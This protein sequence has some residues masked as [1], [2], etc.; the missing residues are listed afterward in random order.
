MWIS[1]RR[2][3]SLYQQVQNLQSDV[4][5]LKFECYVRNDIASPYAD[6]SNTR[7][8][9]PLRDIVFGMAKTLGVK[10]DVDYA[11]DAQAKVTTVRESASE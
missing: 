1:R 6:P 11:K 3:E 9:V 4:A 10:I 5:R 2:F 7:Y 8:A